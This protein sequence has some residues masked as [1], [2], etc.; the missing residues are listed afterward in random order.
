MELRL[1]SDTV[2]TGFGRVDARPADAVTC[3]DERLLG[4]QNRDFNRAAR[5][6]VSQGDDRLRGKRDGDRRIVMAGR[7]VVRPQDARLLDPSQA[8]QFLAQDGMRE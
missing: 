8:G 1:A 6:G 3:A 7:R 5:L 2:G 4:A